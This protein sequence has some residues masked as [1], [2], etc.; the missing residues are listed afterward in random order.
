M[1]INLVDKNENNIALRFS[2][3]EGLDTIRI[4]AN[5]VNW[6]W[7]DCFAKLPINSE[8][9]LELKRLNYRLCLVSP[10]L[11]N[12]SNDIEIYKKYLTE[13]RIKFDAICVKSANINRWK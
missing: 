3:F 13:Q 2:E 12:R 1:I 8:I 5:K 6:I 9:Y 11:Q 10:D 7:V 4:M